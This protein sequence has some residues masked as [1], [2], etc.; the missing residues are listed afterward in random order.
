[1]VNESILALKNEPKIDSICTSDDYSKWKKFTVKVGEPTTPVPFNPFT[2]H[3][4]LKL[5]RLEDGS[6]AKVNFHFI[7]ALKT[8]TGSQAAIKFISELVFLQIVI[9]F[10]SSHTKS[11]RS[12]ACS[13][14][15]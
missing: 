10:W 6:T 2:H 1:M 14:I 7:M 11:I 3:V 13:E 12:I 4:E 8:S 15:L 5:T 9:K